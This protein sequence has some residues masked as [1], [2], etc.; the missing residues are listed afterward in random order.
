MFACGNNAAIR[1]D[2]SLVSSSSFTS[3]VALSEMK[4][5]SDTDDCTSEILCLL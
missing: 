2:H 1:K 4:A 3:A 5:Q